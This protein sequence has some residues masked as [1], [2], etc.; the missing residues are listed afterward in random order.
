MLSKHTHCGWVPRLHPLQLVSHHDFPLQ[1]SHE[2]NAQQVQTL[3]LAA[4]VHLDTRLDEIAYERQRFAGSNFRVATVCQKFVNDLQRGA[5]ALVAAFAT[6]SNIHVLNVRHVDKVPVCVPRKHDLL[7]IRFRLTDNVFRQ[8]SF[9]FAVVR[10]AKLRL[11]FINVL[12]LLLVLDSLD[13]RSLGG[14]ERFDFGNIDER[15]YFI[16][17]LDN[18][19]SLGAKILAALN[20]M[21]SFMIDG[22]QQCRNVLG[23]NVHKLRN[24]RRFFLALQLASHAKLCV[25]NGFHFLSLKIFWLVLAVR[26]VLSVF[27]CRRHNHV[28]LLVSMS[29]C[30]GEKL[31]LSHQQVSCSRAFDFDCC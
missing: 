19:V 23:V 25:T 2:L 6:R 7:Q 8:Q 29:N 10:L 16:S 5:K 18:F 3:Q 1:F 4:V 9:D 13:L 14:C 27:R 15:K 21:R 22:Q 24:V 31:Q 11:L 20:F 26:L 12:F 30:V 17:Q 28:R